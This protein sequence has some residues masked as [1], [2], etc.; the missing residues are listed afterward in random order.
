MRATGAYFV[1]SAG[2]GWDDVHARHVAPRPG[3]RP[4]GY[5][6]LPRDDPARQP[7][8]KASATWRGLFARRLAA[9]GFTIPNDVVFNQ[10]L[11]TCQTPQMTEATLAAPAG[12]RRM[13]VR[14]N[15]L[16]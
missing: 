12:F 11:V 7:S 14:G 16:E 13:L 5:A 8:W 2:A 4:V 3:S 1:F 9:E 6:A 15:R 10:V